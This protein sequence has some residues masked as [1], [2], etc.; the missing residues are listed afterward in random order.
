MKKIIYILLAIAVFWFVFLRKNYVSLGPGVLAPNTPK[1]VKIAFPEL[2]PFKNY[3]ITP[4]AKFHIIAKV[5]SK[6]NYNFG[7]ESELS[8]VDL[9]FGW[10]NMSD[11]SVLDSID[12]SQSNRYYRWWT[13]T[14]P[15][16]RR[17]IESHSANMHLIPGR[18][19]DN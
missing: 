9:A 5:L 15:I 11:E 19:R 4:L 3:T 10:G 17:E 8:S 14:F 2:V 6:E 13:N 1:Q 16:S 18:T 12:I 7:R